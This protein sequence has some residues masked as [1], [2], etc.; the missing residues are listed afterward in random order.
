MADDLRPAD[1]LCD[2]YLEF[3]GMHAHSGSPNGDFT[4]RFVHRRDD[5][6]KVLATMS[7]QVQAGHDGHPGMMVKAYDQMIT[8]LRQALFTADRARA[9]YRNEAQL[10]YPAFPNR[11]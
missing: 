8:V 7:F 6:E 3:D 1:G 2:V 9:F 11:R 5:Q 4:F 10:H